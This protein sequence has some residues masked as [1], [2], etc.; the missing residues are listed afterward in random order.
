MPISNIYKLDK[1]TFPGSI[2]LDTLSN[3]QTQFGIKTQKGRA[4]GNV[5]PNFV[6]TE[7]QQPQINFSTKALDT[8]LG[9]SGA[10]GAAFTSPV[11]NYLKQANTTGSIARA[12]ASHKKAVFNNSLLYWSSIKLPHA[13]QGEADCSLMCNYDGTNDPIIITSSVALAGG[14]SATNYFG[15]GPCYINTVQI[16]GVQEITINCGIKLI[17]AGGE[18]DEFDT[19]IGIE[20]GDPE[21][22]IKTFQPVNWEQLLLRGIALN[23]VSGLTFFAR[24]YL[25]QGS[26][27]TG[28]SSRVP[29]ATAQHIQFQA[30]NGRAIPVST[31]GQESSPISDTLK[32]ECVALTDG[33]VPI[34]ATTL[35][36]IAAP[37]S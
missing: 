7:R 33:V 12:T 9:L 8:L 36:A 4:T 31:D 21:V 11:T 24:K 25:A 22:T 3:V 26:T 23:G 34:I 30:I 27:S 29:N 37:T 2:E 19:F 14:L 35:S 20:M 5:F 28:I 10:G 16:P 13:G 18:S 17:Q 1:I 32:V 15:A 6:C